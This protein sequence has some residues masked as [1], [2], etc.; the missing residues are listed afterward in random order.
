VDADLVT[1]CVEEMV[2][3]L[4]LVDDRET[5]EVR[6]EASCAEEAHCLRGELGGGAVSLRESHQ[7][8]LQPENER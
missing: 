3:R 4:Q 8:I 1:V 5:N 6:P 7:L 2:A